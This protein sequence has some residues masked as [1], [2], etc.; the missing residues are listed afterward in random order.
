MSK[1]ETKS[2][3]KFAK[4]FILMQKRTNSNGHKM[5]KSIKKLRQNLI[6][7][8]LKKLTASSLNIDFLIIF[9]SLF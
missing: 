4:T 6:S 1:I 8:L 9:N 3:S 2:K 7:L 5:K